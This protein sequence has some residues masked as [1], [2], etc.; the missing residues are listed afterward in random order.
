MKRLFQPLFVTFLTVLCLLP[1]LH[2]QAAAADASGSCGTDMTWTYSNGTLHLSGSGEMYE[3]DYPQ[4]ANA[5]PWA[6][7]LGEIHTVTA[8][9][10]V[11]SISPKAFDSADNLR[12]VDL[13]GVERIGSLA[14]W[15]CNKLTQL[16]CPNLV[17]VGSSAFYECNNL[18]QIGS[19]DKLETVEDSAFATTA[20]ESLSLPALQILGDA[21]FNGCASLTTVKLD[22]LETIGGNAFAFSG[23][24]AVDA[25]MV[26]VIGDQAF[27][28]CGSLHTMNAPL[29]ESIGWQAFIN[30][31][32]LNT[33]AMSNVA[34]IAE[35]AF[36]GCTALGALELP[37][38]VTIGK[39]AFNGCTAI[40]ALSLP[41]VQSIDEAA[42]ASCS[43]LGTVDAPKL[44]AIG[45][46]S[47]AYCYGLTDFS[48]PQ[49]STIGGCAFQNCTNLK[50]AEFPLLTTLGDWA[51]SGCSSIKAISYPLLITVPYYAFW[52]CT[53]L[54][55]VNLPKA[56][57]ITGAFGRTAIRHAEFPS[58]TFM[59]HAA[60]YQCRTL[61]TISIPAVE[62]INVGA[63]EQCS[64]LREITVSTDLRAVGDSAFMECYALE[65]VWVLD[66]GGSW[67]VN[68]EFNWN[69]PFIDAPKVSLGLPTLAELPASLSVA[70]DTAAKLTAVSSGVAQSYTWQVCLPDSSDWTDISTADWPT[71]DTNALVYGSMQPE[72]DG[73]KLR[74]LV[75]AYTGEELT[76]DEVVLKYT[77]FSDV[78]A[79]AYYFNPVLWAVDRGITSG[80]SPT[81]FG[82]D[83]PCTRAQVVTFLW[84][85]ADRPTPESTELPFTDVA[86][87][88]YYR[89][90]VLWAVEQGITS[91]TSPTTFG[92]D[93][94]CTRAQIATMMWKAYGDVASVVVPDIPIEKAAA[95]FTDVDASD[96][97]YQAVLWAVE[98]GIT[99]GTSPTTFGP[100]NPCTRA[101]IVTFLYKANS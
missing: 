60:F 92:P 25:P 94:T 87:D 45:T 31:L 86:D 97:Y 91:G 93:V 85:A 84:A 1:C 24:T 41:A 35:E 37:A 79:D 77:P 90:A 38:A 66:K 12:S 56:E 11:K 39:N 47:F 61:E 49:L 81:A 80:T 76:T 7:Y 78:A 57:S 96:W 46:S 30:C 33:P 63:F 16:S 50:A 100:N 13:P 2:T 65:T 36:R 58:L 82:S 4:T 99:A 75:V 19:L 27:Q 53:A 34:S 17:Y 14:F 68:V 29:A 55:T 40:T 98:E 8:D 51:F 62:Q 73:T 74:C 83:A 72:D 21:A 10:G 3:Y 70:K 54:E 69:S 26:R 67:N 43:A 6:Q 48:A 59:G 23:V 22:T 89:N 18:K 9:E 88:A 95:P 28:Q 32:Y 64:G 15:D 52:E 101:Q 20:I 71:A 42:F 5:A 44:T